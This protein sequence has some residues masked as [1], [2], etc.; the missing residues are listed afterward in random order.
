[1]ARC[2]ECGRANP[3]GASHCWCGRPLSTG[4]G[5]AKSTGPGTAKSANPRWNTDY[6]PVSSGFG[7]PTCNSNHITNMRL[8]VMEQSQTTAIAGIIGG[9]TGSGMGTIISAGKIEVGGFSGISESSSLLAQAFTLPKPTW[10]MAVKLASFKHP[11]VFLLCA[12]VSCFTFGLPMIVIFIMASA[13]YSE[14]TTRHQQ[15]LPAWLN[16]CA[17]AF[18]CRVCGLIFKLPTDVRC[19]ET[20]EGPGAAQ[21]A[22]PGEDTATPAEPVPEGAKDDTRTCCYC[23]HYQ[24]HGILSSNYWC[25]KYNQPMSAE[26]TCNQFEYR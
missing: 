8:L 11:I 25:V 13:E 7:C 21:R 19:N 14:L 4:Q 10:W 2:G 23:K 17:T 26:A 12:I 3:E 9:T 18:I 16:F 15:E 24:P 6:L 1:M 20:R 5:A 22:S